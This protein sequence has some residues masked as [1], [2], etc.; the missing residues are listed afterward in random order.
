MKR[1]Y[2]LMAVLSAVFAMFSCDRPEI[3]EGGNTEAVL[4]VIDY[5]DTIIVEGDYPVP[6]PRIPM[7]VHDGSYSA[8]A[9]GVSV[10]VTEVEDR[11]VTFV[12][13]PGAN[14][15]SYAVNVYPLSLMYNMLMENGALDS[16]V[17]A[18]E[19]LIL[20]IMFSGSLPA[21]AFNA[22]SLDTAWKEMEFDWMNTEFSAYMG[23][24]PDA[25]YL[26][27]VAASYEDVPSMTNVGELTLVYVESDAQDIV[28]D[29]QVRIDVLTGYTA[30][31]VNHYPNEDCGGF[32]YFG[33]DASQVDAF[34]EVFGDRMYRDFI[35]H[36]SSPNV[37]VD[38]S[39]SGVHTYRYEFPGVP[40]PEHLFSTAVVAVDVNGTP[41]EC[42][43]E[44]V[45]SIKST[46]EEADPAELHYAV[47]ELGASYAVY[48]IN[49]E[50]SCEIGFCRVM[51]RHQA[52]SI[53]YDCT[54]EQQT[55]FAKALSKGGYATVNENYEM[56]AEAGLLTG[57]SYSSVMFDANLEPETEYVIIYVGRNYYMTLTELKFSEPF[58]TKA[59][60]LDAP[61][62]CLAD[63]RF[64]FTEST[65]TSITFDFR[66][67][68][69][70][71]AKYYFIASEYI[72]FAY[73][74]WLPDK[75]SSREEWMNFFFGKWPD[76][77][78]VSGVSAEDLE[79]GD[80]RMIQMW[81]AD[82][83]SGHEVYVLPGFGPGEYV[84]Y[85]LVAEDK[86]GVISEVL[87]DDVTTTEVVPGPDPQVHLDYE[88]DSTLGVWTVTIKAGKDTGKMRYVVSDDSAFALNYFLSE[89]NYNYYRDKEYYQKWYT[90]VSQLGLPTDSESIVIHTDPGRNCVA[91][92]VG[93]GMDG[94]EEV[95]SPLNYIVLTADGRA[96]KISDIFPNYVEQ[97]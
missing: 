95:I 33:T 28:G 2:L 92:V 61:Q 36:S 84:E 97:L 18:V 54:A 70:N 85:A 94:I 83:P 64:S 1:L 35:R 31:R 34:V 50:A 44:R 25:Q 80:P 8:S 27:A 93:F 45:F 53:R 24:L 11:N 69:A 3:D 17:A 58:T 14:I 26:I 67:D 57:S 79:K 96:L 30:F 66:Y 29:P 46:P 32:Y 82:D 68:P 74:P 73:D 59:R 77:F 19:D 65:R 87:F 42:Y 37:P 62:T 55:Q 81:E 60:I 71:T 56:D 4:P 22:E 6:H 86:N 75:T 63:F 15:K 76:D 52:D 5:P 9:D 10:A 12:C 51:T 38:A 40:D 16:D 49:L 90:Y 21:Y 41:V 89:T 72:D 13:R 91:G 39:E 23:I 78:D 7:L 43:D 20:Q 47:K 88:F 48:E